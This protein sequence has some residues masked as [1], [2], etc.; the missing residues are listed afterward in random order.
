VPFAGLPIRSAAWL[1]ECTFSETPKT[2][3]FGISETP[4]TKEI[5]DPSPVLSQV[6]IPV[7]VSR[8]DA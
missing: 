3:L 1:N 8:Y 5:L 6:G 7:N 2:H 4:N